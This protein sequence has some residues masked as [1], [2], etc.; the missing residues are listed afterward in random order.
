[1]PWQDIII[2]VG[3]WV[4]FVA[5]IPSIR[6]KEKPA[7]LTSLASGAMLLIYVATFATLSLWMSALSSLLGACGWFTL[8]WQRQQGEKN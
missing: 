4:F 7:F 2:A 1:M 6:R 5:L 8:A 3:Q